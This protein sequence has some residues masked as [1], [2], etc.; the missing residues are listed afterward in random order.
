MQTSRLFERLG[1]GMPSLLW[2]GWWLLGMAGL[3]VL[4]Y[5]NTLQVPF[6]LDDLPNIEENPHLRLSGFSLAGLREAWLEGFLPR[7]PVANVSFALNYAVHGYALAGYHWVNL[8]IHVGTGLGLYAL[9]KATLGLPLPRLS[10]RALSGWVP[11]LTVLFWLVHPVQTQSVTY[12]VQRMNSLASLFY[13]LSLWC[14]VRGRLSMGL[15]SR[16]GWVGGCVLAGVLGLGCKEI[17]A[18]LPFF[19]FL[20]EWYFFQGL[21]GGWLRRYGGVFGGVLI[22]LLGLVWWYFGGHLME[23]LLAGYAG[24]DFSLGERL[25]T[26]FRVVVFYLGLLLFPHPSRLNLDHDFAVSHSWLEPWTTLPAVGLVLGLVVVAVVLAR[27]GER[28]LS[29]CLL[30]FLGNL[31]MESSVIGLEL[32]F[33][34]RLYLPSMLLVLLVVVLAGRALRLRRGLTLGLVCT[35]ALVSSGWTWERNAVW[36]DEITLWQDCVTKS[37]GKARP[38]GNY[39]R[40]LLKSGKIEE[41][42]YHFR[43]ALR[44]DPGSTR[45]HYDLGIVLSK[46]GQ[47]EEATAHYREALKIKP[48][49]ADA[50]NSLGFA[51]MNSGNIGEAVAHFRE[52]LRINPVLADAHNNL[53]F[54]LINNGQIEEAIAHYRKA[55]R[56]KPDHELALYNLGMALVSQGKIDE[57]INHYTAALRLLPFAEKLHNNIG[58]ALLKKGDIEKAVSHFRE[59]LRIKPDYSLA[60]RNLQRSLPKMKKSL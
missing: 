40:T 41:T 35:L 34:H 3:V 4:I 57:A 51:L 32:V 20:Y 44:L 39:G 33:E 49:Y 15:G 52:A 24:R 14:Y 54:F 25:L 42:I 12:I 18:T 22:L 26:E 21:S 7:R 31:L 23:A 6:L 16:W 2:E 43:E 56:A 48:D 37:P 8:L 5:S 47:F 45:A 38:H 36:R 55:L 1:G 19:I 53:G 60:Y 50:H 29:F 13:V 59:A 28:L 10:R 17:V 46:T 9:L 58:I 27:R 30:W 11:L